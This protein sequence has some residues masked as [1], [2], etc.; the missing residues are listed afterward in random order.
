MQSLPTS[1]LGDVAAIT[2]ASPDLAKSLAFYQKLG[3]SEVMRYDFPFPW[4][5][6]SDG[7]LLI[8]LRQEADPFMSVTYYV[9]NLDKVVNEVREAGIKFKQEPGKNDMIKRY[10]IETPD[11]VNISLVTHVDGFNNPPG[12]TMLRMPPTDYFNPEK[13]VN[14]ICGLFGEYAHPVKD[15]SASISFWEKLGY[16]V[17]SKRESPYPWAIITD[18]LNVVGLHQSDHFS[19]PAITFFASD[20]QSKIEKLK[21][22]GLENITEKMGP[23]NVVVETPEKQHI[24][25]FSF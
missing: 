3:F 8:F 2:I 16:V 5:Q 6:V 17:L 12:P 22:A 21:A 13:Y 7:A 11:K 1:K 18:G 25:L 10:I 15:I 19:Y 20:M 24:F 4:I 14:K 9:K 23:A